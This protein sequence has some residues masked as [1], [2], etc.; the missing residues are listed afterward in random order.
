MRQ[1]GSAGYAGDGGPALAAL[2]QTPRSLA[3]DGI[4]LLLTDS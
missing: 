3:W 2:M 4:N 1:C